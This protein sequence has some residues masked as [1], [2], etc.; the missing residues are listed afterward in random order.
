M[1]GECHEGRLSINQE[2]T[3]FI[4]FPAHACNDFCIIAGIGFLV[5]T[6]G[7]IPFYYWFMRV[8]LFKLLAER[9]GFEPT[10]TFLLR[11]ISSRVP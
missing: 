1:R 2:K 7:A 4:I 10:V 5:K 8:F 11:S 6:R 9:V 3:P